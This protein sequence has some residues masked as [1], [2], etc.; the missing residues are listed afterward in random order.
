M[1]GVDLNRLTI[2]K[3]IY[4]PFSVE[5]HYF[6]V[7]KRHWSVCFERIKRAGFRI[8]STAVPWNL[9][10]DKNKDIDFN[11]FQDPRKDLI[12]FLELAREFG[13]KVIL[14]PGPWIAGQWPNGGI[15][16]F[17][18]A[19]QT[20]L[21]RDAKGD[22][23][24]LTEVVNVPGGKLVSYLH[25][26]FQH[27]LKNYMKNL[28][29]TTKNYIHPRGPVFLIEFDFE[30]SFCHRTKPL[31]ADYNDYVVTTLYPM[32]LEAKY[33]DI[34]NLNAAYHEKCKSFAEVQPPRDLSDAG[35]KD[36]PKMMDWFQFKEWCLSEF[37]NGLE[38]LFRSYTVLPLFFRSLYFRGE[39]PLPAF[40]LKTAHEEEHLVGASVFPDGTA[41][42][43]MQ[44]ARYMRTM[45]DFAWAPS[46][47]SGSMTTNRSES[48]KMF[49]ITDGRRRYFVA[50]GLAG[51][52]KGFNHYMFINREYWY[53]GPVDQD[54]TIGS[55]FE[56][57]KRLNTA[58][59]KLEINL[60]EPDNA[61]AAAF[62]RPYQWVTDLPHPE[63]LGY[64]SRLL[65][66]SFNGVCRDFS[67]LRFDYGVG[68]IAFPER[69]EKFGTV[70]VPVAEFMSEQAQQNIIALAEKGVNIIL[71]GLLPH[72]D[73]LGREND[74][75]AKALHMK[76]TRSESV[77]EVEYGK[78]QVF[79][80]YLFGTIRSTDPKVKKL[81]TVKEKVV[82]LVS[83]RFKGKVFMFTYDLASGGDF[84]K[85]YHLESIFEEI[86][87]EPAAFVSD[88]NVEV[89]FQKGEKAFVIFLLAPPAGELHDATDVRTKE[90][91][92][93][94]DLRK[95]GFKGAKIKLSDQFADEETPPIKT[96]VDDLKSGLSLSI[97]FPDGKILLVEKI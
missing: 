58:I 59:P 49:P 79:T 72:Y 28:I 62:Y 29:E 66:E 24:S 6:R 83:T 52:F 45:T 8:I 1:L 74:T 3:D 61:L 18:L 9:H 21:A 53:G 84:R 10:Q 44:K 63:K 97:D 26:N 27:Y 2:G 46:F 48:E 51:G 38:E 42:D 20:L 93:K 40:A 75:L 47:I 87:L 19:D 17:V 13:F 41:F 14:R 68:D 35:L 50:A 54:G 70:L 22:T 31:E 5:M 11:G 4:Y 89:V 12:V 25:P 69:L 39:H 82:G 55:G 77:G 36:M 57:I 33:G 15:P 67:H 76:T 73:D 91:L 34:K 86:K 71:T 94:V 7:D 85:L 60:L 80:S 81:A 65:T 16:D 64:I 96:T 32:H 23:V 90:I 95:L 56:I 78:G 92:L 30:T 43:L 37:L 88:P